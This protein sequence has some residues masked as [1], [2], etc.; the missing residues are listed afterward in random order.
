MLLLEDRRFYVYVFLDPTKPGY[1]KY[2]KYEFYYCPFY[3]GKGHGKRI[4]ESKCECQSNSFKY[5]KIQKLKRSNLKPLTL[6]YIENLTEKESFDL[7]INMI[8]TIGR[9]DKKL[10]P[11]TNLTDGGEGHYGYI[12]SEEL[13]TIRRKNQTGKRLSEKSKKKIS[14]SK[15]GYK[16]PNYGKTLSEEVKKKI[17][18]KIKGDKHPF[19]GKPRSK[20]TKI[21]LIESKGFSIII[22]NKYYPS[23]REAG[24]V[25]NMH[26]TT[27]GRRLKSKNFPNYKY[28]N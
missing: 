25:L 12:C 28:A 13:K 7:E 5:K 21:K 19:F 16:N 23:I 3:I 18:D 22:D 4:Y 14:V 10:G 20:E 26:N 15:K 9:R 24:R 17:S 2:G 8:K 6:K 1:Y 11:L 27:I